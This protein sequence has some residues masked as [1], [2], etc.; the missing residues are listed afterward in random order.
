[1]NK[2]YRDQGVILKV[3]A[4]MQTDMLKGPITDDFGKAEYNILKTEYR[5]IY[6]RNPVFYSIILRYFD[7]WCKC[8]IKQSRK[9][10]EEQN[11]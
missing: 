4:D 8:M 9:T 11:G 5:E 10:A 1:M 3:V 6:K 7:G 2:R